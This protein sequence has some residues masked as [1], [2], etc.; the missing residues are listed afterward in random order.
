[1]AFLGYPLTLTVEG[2]LRVR[3]GGD[4]VTATCPACEAT[5]GLRFTL[6]TETTSEVH[7]TCAC[8]RT[9]IDSAI[10]AR[11]IRTVAHDALT[12]GR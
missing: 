4:I 5:T 12:W 2:R 1:M 6:H 11:T 3:V 8:G 9:W 10:P 7:V